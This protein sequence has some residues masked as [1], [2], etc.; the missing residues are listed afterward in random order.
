MSGW[1]DQCNAL[2][3]SHK[4]G[5]Y[6][7]L[8]VLQPA[9]MPGH[10]IDSI[11]PTNPPREH[12]YS[13]G[14]T[15]D[16]EL[17]SPAAVRDWTGAPPMFFV[18]GSE[19]RGIDGNRVVASQAAKS[20]MLVIWNEYEGMP[21]DFNLMMAKLPQAKHAMALLGACVYRLYCIEK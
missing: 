3:S 17:V 7:I 8:E 15:L 16:H 6:D 9:S 18:C 14:E 13:A 10:P 1:C 11:W 21:H 4:N 2:P 12:P 19:E 20:G 5:E